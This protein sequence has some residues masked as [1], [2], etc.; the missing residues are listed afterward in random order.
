MDVKCDGKA[1]KPRWGIVG[2]VRP[3]RGGVAQYTTMLHREFAREGRAMTIAYRYI[4]PRWIYPGKSLHEPG[5]AIGEEPGVCYVLNP[6]NPLSSRRVARSFKAAGVEGVIVMWWTVFLA[7]AI[8]LLTLSLRRLDIPVCFLCHNISDHEASWW[9]QL[10]ARKVLSMG[11]RF[12]VHSSKDADMLKTF[13]PSSTVVTHPHPVYSQFPEPKRVLGRCADLEILFF[14]LVRHYKGLDVLAKAM[15]RLNDL[16]VHL[17]VVGEWWIKD[18]KLKASLT[19][20][21]HIDVVDKYVTDEEVSEYFNRADVV[22]LPY[23]TATGSGVISLAYHYGKAVIATRVGGI[24]D[25]VEDGVSGKLIDAEDPDALARAIKWFLNVSPGQLTEGVKKV[26]GRMTWESLA[27]A[28]T[29][30]GER[31]THD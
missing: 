24:P 21:P 28:I 18:D 7:P 12:L 11:N 8:G 16:P 14:G 30:T 4:Y 6:Y 5:D 1:T 26:S 13:V 17:S 19:D 15:E 25:V 3:F 23:R 22:V 10:T 20:M 29:A 2:P 9:K 31:G 27:S